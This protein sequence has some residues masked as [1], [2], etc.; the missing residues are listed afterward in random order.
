MRLRVSD[1][2]ATVVRDVIR[3]ESTFENSLQDDLVIARADGTPL[4]HLAVVVDDL[5]I[6]ITHIIRGADHYSNT[7]EA[8][9]DPPGAGRGAAA[10][11]RVD[12]LEF[13]SA[14]RERPRVAKAR[15]VEAP[16]DIHRLR[17]VQSPTA[18][19]TDVVARRADPLLLAQ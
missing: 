8:D 16:A 11:S 19:P 6:G 12:S 5:D 2:G 1:D 3:G 17:D 15:K 14:D 4:Y 7:A 9:A 10:T 13:F 18:D